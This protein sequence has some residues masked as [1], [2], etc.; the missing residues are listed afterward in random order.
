MVALLVTVAAAIFATFAHA[1]ERTELQVQVCRV[2]LSEQTARE[3][4]R[5]SELAAKLNAAL[6]EIQE[7]KDAAKKTEGKK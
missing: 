2:Q 4:E 7:L 3:Q 6:R 1:D 5:V